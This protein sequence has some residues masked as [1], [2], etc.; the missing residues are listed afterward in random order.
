MYRQQ[1]VQ[2]SHQFETDFYEY[3]NLL[4]NDMNKLLFDGLLALE[5]IKNFEDLREDGDAWSQLDQ[6]QRE[7]TESNY[8]D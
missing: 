3:C 2:L 1:F 6:E 8:N 7:Q 4:I 5:E